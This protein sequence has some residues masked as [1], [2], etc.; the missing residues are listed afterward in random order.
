L[1]CS[2]G[3]T[4]MRASPVS[5]M[6]ARLWVCVLWRRPDPKLHEPVSL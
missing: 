1:A 5:A 3:V 4:K 2:T 6:I